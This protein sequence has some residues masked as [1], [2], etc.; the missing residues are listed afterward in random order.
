MLLVLVAR[1]VPRLQT[2]TLVTTP[3][4]ICSVDDRVNKDNKDNKVLNINNKCKHQ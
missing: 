4:Q 2:T 3:L 1:L